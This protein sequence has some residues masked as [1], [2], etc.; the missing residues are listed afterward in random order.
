[1]VVSWCVDT[2]VPKCAYGALAPTA[3]SC[4]HTSTHNLQPPTHLLLIVIAPK[5]PAEG[6]IRRRRLAS[7]ASATLLCSAPSSLISAVGANKRARA[8]ATLLRSYAYALRAYA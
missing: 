4:V 8:K 2:R 1:M 7:V 3:H 6:R 5:A